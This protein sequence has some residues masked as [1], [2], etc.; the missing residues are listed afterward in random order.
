MVDKDPTLVDRTGCLITE[1]V[2][3][4]FVWQDHQYLGR[5]E[6]EEMWGGKSGWEEWVPFLKKDL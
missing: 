6:L 3:P 4:G 1:V 2:F 5:T